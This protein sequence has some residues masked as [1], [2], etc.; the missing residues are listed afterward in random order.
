MPSAY[1]PGAQPLRDDVDE[2]VLEVLGD[3][4]HEG[5]ADGGRQQQADAAE[6]LAGAVLAIAGGV[7]V[8]DVPEDQRVEQR[9]DLVDGR[10]A[11]GQDDKL[12]IVTQV[13]EQQG[14]AVST[15]HHTLL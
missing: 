5:H 9:E 13:A 6:E 8:D 14:H 7:L 2:V 11:Q 10:Q 1:K 4:G 15:V 12:A 3:A